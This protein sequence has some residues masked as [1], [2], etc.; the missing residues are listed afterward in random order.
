MNPKTDLE[1]IAL[2]EKQLQFQAF[3]AD[4][5]WKVG[6]RLRALAAERKLAVAI[7]I[8]VNGQQLFFAATPG[9]TPDNSDWIRRKRNVA[10]RYQRSSY[11]MGLQLQIQ[12]TTLT[13]QAGVDARDYIPHG[14]CFPIHLA[15]TGC[16]GTITVSGLPQRAD[17]ELVVEVLA[18]VLGQS[19]P[20]LALD[21]S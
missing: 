6:S 3:N 2:Q 21:P 16:I 13:E 11:A 8:Q 18:E 19:Y 9:A 10:L 7:D 1:K 14:G 17:H 20:D 15:G 12:G 4:T 5:A